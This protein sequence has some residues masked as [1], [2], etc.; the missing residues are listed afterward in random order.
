MNARDFSAGPVVKNL[1]SNAGNTSLISCWGT[2]MQRAAGWLSP[3]P[4]ATEPRSPYMATKSQ[5]AATQT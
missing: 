3:Y 5:H 1:S 2:K 4:V